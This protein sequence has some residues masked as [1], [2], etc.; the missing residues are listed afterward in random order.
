MTFLAGEEQL[1]SLTF[2]LLG[3]FGG[4]TWRAIAV[5]FPVAVIGVVVL[6]RLARTIRYRYLTSVVQ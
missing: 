4:A 3:G 5:T 1:Q 2:W 6:F